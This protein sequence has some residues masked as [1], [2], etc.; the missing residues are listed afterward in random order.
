[1]RLLCVFWLALAVLMP[2]PVPVR[3]IVTIK[4]PFYQLVIKELAKHPDPGVF[5]E[6]YKALK[7]EGDLKYVLHEME[8]RHEE[9][10]QKRCKGK[11]ADTEEKGLDARVLSAV[12]T[13]D[14]ARFSAQN[15]FE[16][17]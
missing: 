14:K 16:L 6:F 15:F 5:C 13:G 7:E 10:I 3:A 4:D 17:F 9:A 2:L 8:I 12:V 11:N 1:M